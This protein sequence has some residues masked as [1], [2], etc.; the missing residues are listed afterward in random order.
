MKR[1]VREKF[2]VEP[3]IKEFKPNDKVIL[4]INPAARS[5]PPVRY[6]GF[7]GTITRKQG[8]C[9]VVSIHDGNKEKFMTL[10]PD[11]LKLLRHEA[12]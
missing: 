10:S 7:I 2:T 12:V 3:L 11:H 8:S 9:Y 5:F 1:S 4:K 6:K